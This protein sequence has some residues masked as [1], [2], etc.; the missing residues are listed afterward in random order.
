MSIEL[1]FVPNLSRTKPNRPLL[2]VE[3]DGFHQTIFEP[4]DIEGYQRFNT[5]S[6]DSRGP[7]PFC[8]VSGHLNTRTFWIL[9][10]ERGRRDS[11]E[12]IGRVFFVVLFAGYLQ[13]KKSKIMV[14]G[15]CLLLSVTIF[16]YYCVKAGSH[17]TPCV[18][19]ASINFHLEQL[20]CGLW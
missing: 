8:L 5:T 11:L 18:S 17:L 20:H 9:W 19:V 4:P 6:E 16:H 14:D 3:V 2:I 15:R 12:G 1:E 10:T 7:D 13:E